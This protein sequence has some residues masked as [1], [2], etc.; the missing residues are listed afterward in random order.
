MRM[1]W[2]EDKASERVKRLTLTQDTF[3]DQRILT[4]LVNGMQDA[5]KDFEIK[6]TSGDGVI[7]W[8][9]TKISEVSD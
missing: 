5:S 9:R 3:A 8:S 1:E 4:A 6:I 7:K 2:S